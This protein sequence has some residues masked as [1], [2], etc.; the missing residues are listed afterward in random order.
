MTSNATTV[1]DSLAA[2]QQGLQVELALPSHYQQQNASSSS[3]VSPLS[4][5]S[6][7]TYMP[8]SASS[9]QSSVVNPTSS[10]SHS[11][12]M[13]SPY[14]LDGSHQSQQQQQQVGATYPGSQYDYYQH[15]RPRDNS[16][17][18]SSA[19]LYAQSAMQAEQ[20]Q[21]QRPAQAWD[22]QTRGVLAAP[23]MMHSMSAPSHAQQE[24]LQ[25]PSTMPGPN[26]TQMP[27]GQPAYT[28]S[29]VDYAADGWS[30]ASS[31]Y[32]WTTQQQQQQQQNQPPDRYVFTG[33]SYQQTYQPLS[34]PSMPAP[35]LAASMQRPMSASHV[36][37]Q[38]YPTQ[39][40]PGSPV[41]DMRQLQAQQQQQAA[42]YH[43]AA[44]SPQ[45]SFAPS[46]HSPAD[47]QRRMSSAYESYG[48]PA[49][50]VASGSP[51]AHSTPVAPSNPLWRQHHLQ[52]QQQ[53]QGEG[54]DSGMTL[55]SPANIP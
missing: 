5:L 13:Y 22:L 55:M 8:H 25:R 54:H 16:A 48:S 18:P 43:A 37:Q 27:M 29:A 10:S 31:P 14:S 35:Q 40:H 4:T 49:A 53:Q 17:G 24:Q 46:Y 7:P 42:M 44:T 26:L 21:G 38:L 33:P 23:S 12:P 36:Q 15:Q 20:L 11:A 2:G 32:D 28:A 9:S 19:A 30:A 1:G 6:E 52:Q 39:S 34:G 3:L 47:Q 45:A 51:S 41:A 50:L